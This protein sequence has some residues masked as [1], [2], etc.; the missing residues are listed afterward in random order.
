MA[1]GSKSRSRKT[2]SSG[3]FATRSTSRPRTS[4]AI[5]YSQK[6]PG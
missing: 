3:F 2:W 4:V 6:V 1:S 5:E